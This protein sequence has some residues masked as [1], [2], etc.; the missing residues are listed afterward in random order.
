M[1]REFLII[2]EELGC[3]CNGIAENTVPTWRAWTRNKYKFDGEARSYTNEPVNGGSSY[4]CALLGSLL[5]GPL[6]HI[7][8]SDFVILK[9]LKKRL[10]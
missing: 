9:P 10:A 3:A 7:I 2:A 1:N 4:I 5:F 8:G 6:C